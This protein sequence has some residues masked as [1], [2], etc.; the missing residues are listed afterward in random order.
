MWKAAN[1]DPFAP[2]TESFLRR[3]DRVTSE[4]IRANLPHA[5]VTIQETAGV[6]RG[7]RDRRFRQTR[8]Y[9]PGLGVKKGGMRF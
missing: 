5:G 1:N 2:N 6:N 7:D 8:S 4:R 3:F 9:L